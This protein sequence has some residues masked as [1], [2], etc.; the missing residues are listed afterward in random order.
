MKIIIT[1]LLLICITFSLT[2]CTEK[3]Y[4]P[5]VCF[6]DN[7][8]PIFVSKCSTSGCHTSGARI[9]DFTTY[10]G[11][12][13]K[14]V[15]KHPLRSSIYTKIDGSNPSMP[16]K[17]YTALTSNEIFMIKAWISMGALNQSNCTIC[18]TTQYKF[19]ADIQ[20]IMNTYCV[21][22]HSTNNAGGGYDL[23]N[24]AGVVNSISH[25]NLIN[26]I[27]HTSGYNPMPQNGSQLPGCQISKIESWINAGNPNN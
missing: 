8:L 3:A 17:D 20:P 14:V 22:C 11:V 2:T 23:S 26:S 24:Y 27:K 15:A 10:D 18:D 12:M 19:G 6:Q 21:G 1:V 4:D 9:G 16:P 25:N 13:R 7:I 5:N